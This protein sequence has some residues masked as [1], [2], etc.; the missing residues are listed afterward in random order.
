[1]RFGTCSSCGKY[2]YISSNGRCPSCSE[3]SVHIRLDMIDDKYRTPD[4]LKAIAESISSV[5]GVQCSSVSDL[6]HQ[7]Q[8]DLDVMEKKCRL[9]KAEKEYEYEQYDKSKQES[10]K[11][12][13]REAL[14]DARDIYN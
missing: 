11:L 1:M 2:K 5:E 6:N 13:I 9:F 14:N 4:M 7:K 10:V 3:D 8:D 12:A